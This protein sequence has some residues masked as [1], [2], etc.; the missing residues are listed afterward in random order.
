MTTVFGNPGS[1]ELRLFR[2][3]PPD[4]RYVLALQE[5]SAVAMAD[6]F[7]QASGRAAFV[8]LHSAI[9]IGHALGSVF[10]A[11]R[12]YTPLVITA[13][14]QTRALLPG[15]P[16]LFAQDATLFPR[17]YVKWAAEP[18]RPEDVPAAMARAYHE[19]MAR[20]RGPVFVS[21]PEDDWDAPAEPVTARTVH[22]ELSADP[23]GLDAL[24]A[25]LHRARRPCLV[26]GAGVDRDDAWQETVALAERTG[27]TVWAAPLSSRCGFPEDHPS[28]S[29]F[30][31][32]S[33]AKLTARL[34]GHDVVV[35]LGAPVFTYHVHSEGSLLPD[36]AVLFQLTD[37][38]S[39]AARASSGTAIITTLRPAL[40]R[41]LARLALLAPADRAAPTTRPAPPASVRPP[42][43]PAG[44]PIPAE[45]VLTTVRRLMPDD[46]VVVE[47]APTHRRAMHDHLP[48]TIPGG[49]YAA[50]SGGLGWALPASVGI[51]L[52]SPGRRVLCLLGEG[53]SMY[54][55][56]ALWSA[57]QLDLPIAFIVLDN[58]AYLALKALGGA[59]GVSDPPGVDLPGLNVAAI[60]AG[61][62]C[63]AKHVDRAGQLAPALGEALAASG[64]TLTT[65]RVDATVEALY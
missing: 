45:L 13:G 64:P 18:A 50:A 55:I 44:D 48:I 39:A 16:Y 7:A 60:A 38:P 9:G 32:P 47:E 15:E 30:L 57:V 4:F 25:A 10:T 22:T 11:M 28:F 62:G 65:V 34:A 46:A 33:R 24:A 19:A 31:E 27:A 12:N 5:S 6:G 51:A 8:N 58:R 53:S 41:L 49:F 2:D 40:A 43:P 61:F 3:W 35:V 26:A 23:A 29:G 1:T 52:A 17:P 63:P 21:V 59:F 14:Q 56:Q 42:G 20:P 54:S 37:D 36:D